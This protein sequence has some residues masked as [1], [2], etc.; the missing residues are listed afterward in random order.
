MFTAQQHFDVIIYRYSSE[1]TRLNIAKFAD[2]YEII[3]S[4]KG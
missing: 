3:F 4:H 1:V 2:K